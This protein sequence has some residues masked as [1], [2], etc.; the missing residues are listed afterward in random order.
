MKVCQC[1][2]GA[3]LVLMEL[4]LKGDAWPASVLCVKVPKTPNG[5]NAID[6]RGFAPP[7]NFNLLT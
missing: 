5:S 4:N 6:D 7:L 2:H 3:I 1:G